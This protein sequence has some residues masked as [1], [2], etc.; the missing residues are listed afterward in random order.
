MDLS[1][2]Y[3]SEA[4]KELRAFYERLP[5]A[6]STKQVLD[7]RPEIFKKLAAAESLEK[8]QEVI[9][10]IRKEEDELLKDDP[11]YVKVTGYI[12]AIGEESLAG[13]DYLDDLEEDVRDDEEDEKKGGDSTGEG[14]GMEVSGYYDTMVTQRGDIVFLD[15][16]GRAAGN[17]YQA[18]YAKDWTHVGLYAMNNQVYDSYPGECPAN[19]VNTGGV[20]LRDAGLYFFKSGSRL[21]MAQL[22][23]ASQRL[24]QSATLTKAQNRFGTDCRTPFEF[25]L[26]SKYGTSSF[27]CSKLVWRAHKDSDDYPVDLDSNS[28]LYFYWLNNSLDNGR[29]PLGFGIS[30]FIVFST[31]SPDEIAMDGDMNNYARYRYP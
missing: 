10:L 28:Y 12:E 13:G 20:A 31:V 25:S 22:S 27:Y 17:S 7:A 11:V 18:H 14:I 30:W 19:A 2:M 26:F 1:D 9:A 23:A 3:E 4:Y 29:I 5:I 24:T 6:A 8:Q 21:M 15:A 16:R